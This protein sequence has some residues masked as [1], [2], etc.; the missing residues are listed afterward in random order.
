MNLTMWSRK[1]VRM[2]EAGDEGSSGGGQGDAGAA[3]NPGSADQGS[4]DP[5]TQAAA[6]PT[7]P[8]AIAPAGTE[9]KETR[10]PEKFRVTGADGQIDT[11]AS[12]AKWAESHTHLE[13]RMAAGDHPLKSPEEYQVTVPDQFKEHWAADH[14]EFKEF[15]AAAHA[16]GLTQAQFG[17]FMDKYF[18]I[19]PAVAQGAQALDEDAA[20]ATLRESWANDEQ[21]EQGVRDANLVVTRLSEISGIP[22]EQAQNSGLFVNPVFIQMM[23]ALA[24]EFREDTPPGDGGSMSTGEE[25]ASLMANPAYADPKHPQHAAVSAK[26]RAYYDRKHGGAPIL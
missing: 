3:A 19:I 17:F 13:K 23:A 15:A 22:M 14:P 18:E 9:T 1:H 21:Y 24:P 16:Q 26:V 8:A 11:E 6:Q 12:L 25:I 7:T 20:R 10:I 5:A 4:A 2:Q